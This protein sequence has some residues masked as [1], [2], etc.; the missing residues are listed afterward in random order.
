MTLNEKALEAAAIVVCPLECPIEE[1]HCDAVRP[2]AIEQTRKIIT[3][4]FS[5]LRAL[6]TVK[7]RADAADAGHDAPDTADSDSPECGG[8]DT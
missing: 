2:R 5:A 3:A 1:C 4:Y 6:N 8:I 7:A